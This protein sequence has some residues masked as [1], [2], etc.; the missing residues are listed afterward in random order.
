[1]KNL[2]ISLAFF[3]NSCLSLMDRSF[4]FQLIKSY[5]ST[6]SS[7]ALLLLCLHVILYFDTIIRLLKDVKFITSYRV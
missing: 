3:I 2:N 1:V 6:V 7:S 4:I 5:C